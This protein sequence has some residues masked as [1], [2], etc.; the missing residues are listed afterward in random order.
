MAFDTT[1]FMRQRPGRQLEDS[2]MRQG[3][4][5]GALLGLDESEKKRL[6]RRAKSDALRKIAFGSGATHWAE[7]LAQTLAGGLSGWEDRKA[8]ESE[9]A[10]K[11]MRAQVYGD[12]ESGVNRAR[13]E[14]AALPQQYEAA[15]ATSPQSQQRFGLV[16]STL[17]PK[18]AEG[19]QQVQYGRQLIAAG[20]ELRGRQLIE[21]GQRKIDAYNEAL[22]G[23]YSEGEQARVR[24]DERSTDAATRAAERAAD[25]AEREKRAREDERRF[26]VTESRM[27]AQMNQ[28][29]WDLVPD[30]VRGGYMRINQRTGETIPVNFPA[31]AAAADN[32]GLPVSGLQVTQPGGKAPTESESK[33]GTRAGVALGALG[34][35]AGQDPKYRKPGL[36][37]TGA[38]FFGLPSSQQ[39]LI[40]GATAGPERNLVR[41]AQDAFIDA[42]L[43]EMTGAAYTEHQINAF[44]NRFMPN[45]FDTPETAAIKAEEAL[46]FVRQQ[47]VAAGRAWTPERD[48]QFRQMM[49]SVQENPRAQ[50]Q[51]PRVNTPGGLGSTPDN[52]IILR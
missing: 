34:T 38:Q 50:Q 16:R 28:A 1:Q 40:A 6:Q 43:T 22:G 48:M 20:D 3:P 52:P 47:A 41:G 9:A 32:T 33:S 46:N 13:R 8:N 35:T 37:E 45:Y 39:T 11:R 7:A 25:A 10:D 30:P 5:F 36:I 18:A 21:D 31:T 15:G 23:A 44:R 19:E 4:N 29:E 42:A 51:G 24:Q 49:Q 2:P 14:P 17:G 12:I 26:G 27:R